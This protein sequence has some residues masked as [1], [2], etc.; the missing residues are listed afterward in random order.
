ML[1]E[2]NGKIYIKPFSNK[3]VE[4]EIS[5]NIDE[6]DVKPTSKIL[7]LTPKIRN[8]LTE[9]TLEDAYK[10]I[11]KNTQKEFNTI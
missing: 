1:Y 10:K 11:N 7:I 5:K 8:K 9:I 6:F 2:Y 4:V 3:L